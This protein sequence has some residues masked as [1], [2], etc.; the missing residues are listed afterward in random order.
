[1]VVVALLAAPAFAEP[2]PRGQQ[3][4]LAERTVTVINR[5]PRPVNEIYVSPQSNDQWG[6][7]RLGNGT[8]DVGGFLRV[9]LG[10]TRECLFDLKVIY[11]DASEEENRGVDLCHTG[12]VAFD[13]HAATAAPGT[14]AEHHVVLVN[15]S[16]QPIQQ[17]Y[18]SPA[19]AT[20]WGDDRLGEGSI[21]VKDHRD[22]TWRGDCDVDVRVVFAN[23]AAEE[24]RGVD[25]C[26]APAVS[27]E[28]GWTTAE[29]LPVP[30]ADATASPGR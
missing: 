28:P 25:L 22:L 18:I 29:S 5:S 17:V 23:H 1:M 3:G 13:G 11:D 24:R 14:G 20:Q 12:V 8:L 26:Q 2:P 7:D 27:I 10:R 16:P 4:S 30:K 9:H 19:E 15:H 21:S 6:E